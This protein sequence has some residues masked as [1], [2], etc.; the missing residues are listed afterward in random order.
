VVRRLGPPPGKV[1]YGF[2]AGT[3]TRDEIGRFSITGWTR[4]PFDLAAADVYRSE[5]RALFPSTDRCHATW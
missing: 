2:S 1:D 5:Q 3:A 4:E